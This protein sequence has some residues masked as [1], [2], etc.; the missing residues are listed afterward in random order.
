MSSLLDMVDTVLLAREEAPQLPLFHE[1]GVPP[2]DAERR[3]RREVEDLDVLF[4]AGEGG[5]DRLVHEPFRGRRKSSLPP[6]AEHATSV[7]ALEAALL[8]AAGETAAGA[9][10]T[11]GAPPNYRSGLG[12]LCRG[13]RC[14]AARRPDRVTPDFLLE[15]PPWR[16]LVCRFCG[17]KTTARFAASKLEGRFHAVGAAYAKHVLPA[18]LVLFGSSAE[19]LAA[20]FEPAQRGRTAAADA[21]AR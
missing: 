13:E 9:A 18:N 1:L 12:I 4:V 3:A 10:S 14:V 11:D 16:T 7:R 19:A 5:R 2:G 6:G 20:G 8:Y 17:E 21:E 15:G